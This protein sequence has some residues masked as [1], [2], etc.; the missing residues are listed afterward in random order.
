MNRI[1]CILVFS[2]FATKSIAQIDPMKDDQFNINKP[3]SSQRAEVSQKIGIGFIKVN[4]SRPNV[5]NRTIFD[6]LLKYG[7]VWRLGADYQTIIDFQNEFVIFNDTIPKGKYALYAIPTK[8]EWK[9]LLNSDTKG[10]GQYSYKSELNVY[11]FTVPVEK[12]P[13]FTETFTI[14]FMNTSMNQGELYFQWENIRTR[15]PITI[16]NTHR[17]SIQNIYEFSLGVNKQSLGYRY[18]LVSEY[19]FLEEQDYKKAL[20]YIQKAIDNG[21]DRYDVLFLKAKVLYANGNKKEA[22]EVLKL[23]KKKT[24]TSSES[25]DWMYRIDQKISD[26][27]G[28]K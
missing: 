21:I 14:G 7:E 9:I 5:R 26:W 8:N 17:K 24:P 18:Y 6:G 16:G 23:A 20:E 3:T 27:K 13:E 12:S 25:S 4:Y 1:I 22:I 2:I 15:L 28:K 10:W 11:E 19:L